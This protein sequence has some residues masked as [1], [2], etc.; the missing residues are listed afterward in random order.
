MATDGIK[1]TTLL[2]L[3]IAQLA[4]LSWPQKRYLLR[5]TFYRQ[6]MQCKILSKSEAKVEK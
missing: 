5:L 4:R 6:K 1:T 2:Y 3:H